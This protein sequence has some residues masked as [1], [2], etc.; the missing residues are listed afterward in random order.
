MV[1]TTTTLAGLSGNFAAPQA[2]TFTAT[3]TGGNTSAPARA[4]TQTGT[5]TF[6]D[7]NVT[8]PSCA[9]VALGGGVATCTVTLGA[10]THVIRAH[11]N[12]DAT[13]A[14]SDSTTTLT[15]VIAQQVTVNVAPR[16]VPEG[17]TLFLLGG[18]MSGLGVWLRWQW[19]KRRK[20]R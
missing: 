10:G 4:P 15:L 13:F 12:G 7:N 18:G 16:E 20:V 14:A 9:N 8:I 3:V 17:D 1:A 5:V 19:G 11:Y 6:Y 2:F